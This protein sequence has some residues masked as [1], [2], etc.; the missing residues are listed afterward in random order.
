MHIY[1]EST[2][3]SPDVLTKYFNKRA[4]VYYDME[5]ESVCSATSS[6]YDFDTENVQSESEFVDL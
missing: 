5:T 2:G 6:L 4:E 1:A 3:I